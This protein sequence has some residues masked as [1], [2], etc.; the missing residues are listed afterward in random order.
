MYP[1]MFSGLYIALGSYFAESE[2]FGGSYS[3]HCCYLVIVSTSTIKCDYLSWF[4][5]RLNVFCSNKPRI[6]KS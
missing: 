4:G 6:Q 5:G 2:H 3:G 1:A